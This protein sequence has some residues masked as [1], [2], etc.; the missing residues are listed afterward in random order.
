[1]ERVRR[2][3]LPAENTSKNYDAPHSPTWGGVTQ[4]NLFLWCVLTIDTKVG[5]NVS[6]LVTTLGIHVG[7]RLVT[8]G[9]NISK[10]L[11]R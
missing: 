7:T 2:A 6:C 8:I 10:C 11:A 4:K 5:I 9:I 1:M 3:K